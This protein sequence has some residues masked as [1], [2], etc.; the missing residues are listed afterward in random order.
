MERYNWGGIFASYVTAEL[1]VRGLL[2][3]LW[4]PLAYPSA[5]AATAR[6]APLGWPWTVEIAVLLLSNLVWLVI[7]RFHDVT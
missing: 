5:L 6:S 2:G 7:D 1:Y 3:R 4:T